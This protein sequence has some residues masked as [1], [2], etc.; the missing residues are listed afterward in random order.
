MVNRKERRDRIEKT[1]E[2][3]GQYCGRI[4]RIGRI[5]W[6]DV[7]GLRMVWGGPLA[8]KGILGWLSWAYARGPRS[9]PGWYGTRRWRWGGSGSMACFDSTTDKR[10]VKVKFR[11]TNL[12]C[13][14]LPKRRY[15]CIVSFVNSRENAGAAAKSQL[16]CAR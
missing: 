6:A 9:D 14:V 3:A 1:G 4:G 15:G 13:G 8:L 11:S 10:N 16:S 2:G 7:N 12:I 5:G